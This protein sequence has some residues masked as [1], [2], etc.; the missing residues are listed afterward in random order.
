M[1]NAINEADGS[2]AANPDVTSANAYVEAAANRYVVQTPT[3][4]ATHQIFDC[5][6]LTGHTRTVV[7]GSTT[8]AI[9][10]TGMAGQTI[11]GS[12]TV[13]PSTAAVFTAQLVSATAGGCLWLR[14]Q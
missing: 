2:T 7:N 13:A 6:A 8:N 3:A 12:A 10:V 1:A 4:A 11:Q 14:T 5:L 9:T